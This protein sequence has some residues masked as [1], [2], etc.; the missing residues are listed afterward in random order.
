MSGEEFA[1][2]RSIHHR[3]DILASKSCGCFY[4]GAI[5]PPERITEWTDVTGDGSGQTALCPECGIDS[6]IGDRSGTP[7]TGELL[8]E[9]HAYWF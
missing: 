9:M 7:I 2:R 6:V 5:F 4:C 3:V 1:H 8:T